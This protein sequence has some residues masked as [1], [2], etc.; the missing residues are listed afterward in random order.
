M[1]NGYTSKTKITDWFI[2]HTFMVRHFD[3][4]QKQ[5]I[6]NNFVSIQ[7]WNELRLAFD[8]KLHTKMYYDT[9][10][11]NSIKHFSN[12]LSEKNEKKNYQK[13]QVLYYVG[14]W[15]YLW[16]EEYNFIR[17]LVKWIWLMYYGWVYELVIRIWVGSFFFQFKHF[18]VHSRFW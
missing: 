18:E 14:C 8:Y 9:V 17:L 15:Y 3:R 1:T 6:N 7:I 2:K 16:C 4:I 13:S 10:R 11:R 12:S 5:Q